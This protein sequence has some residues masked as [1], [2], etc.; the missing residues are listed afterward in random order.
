MTKQLHIKN[1]FVPQC[2]L[3]RWEE[4][5]KIYVYRTLVSNENVPL[6][7]RYSTSAIAYHRHLY[8]QV[9]SGKETDA[10][11]VWFDQEFESPA[12][13]VIEKATSDKKLSK[14][15]WNILIRFLALQDVRTPARMLEHL[16]RGEKEMPGILQDVLNDLKMK[17]E[18]KDYESL[19]KHDKPAANSE[20]LPI[21]VATEFEDGK[22]DGT[23]KVESYIGRSSWIHSMRHL[24]EHTE[25]I[26]H[27][28]KWSIV[29]PAKG[30]YWFTSD[31][32]VIKLNY[33]NSNKYD[34]RGG[35]GV[36]K[37]NIIFPIGPE[38]AMF[39]QIGD[40][41]IPKGTR[42]TV[43]QTVELRKFMAEN[44]HRMIFSK[45]EDREVSIFR[46]RVVDRDLIKRE[47]E[48]MNNWHERNSEMEQDYFKCDKED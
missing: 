29:K 21:K 27:S 9:L 5:K 46:K 16:K 19:R 38:H 41:P 44:A 34:L 4:D 18:N 20:L 31:N 1:H 8:T 11:E 33:I 40:R 28:H 45:G 15:D 12:N 26:L 32:P 14:E 39:V 30:Y 35:W 36:N 3:K 37:G 42:L 2:Y 13:E 6:W 24:L 23:I 22:E 17:L 7:N 10:M 43:A 25:K 47:N 48:E